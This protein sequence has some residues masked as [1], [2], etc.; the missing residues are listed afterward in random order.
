MMTSYSAL[1]SRNV[2]STRNCSPNI[3]ERWLNPSFSLILHTQSLYQMCQTDA[4]CESENAYCSLEFWQ[5]YCNNA[6]AVAVYE[7]KCVAVANIRKYI[8]NL[9]ISSPI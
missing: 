2:P 1:P 5:C 6:H 9:S 4:D 8:P 3:L 7:E